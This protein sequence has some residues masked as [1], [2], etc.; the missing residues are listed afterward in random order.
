MLKKKNFNKNGK[1]AG[2]F[3]YSFIYFILF[4]WQSIDRCLC[5]PLPD[6]YWGLKLQKETSLET[7]Y[8]KRIT[9]FWSL[10]MFETVFPPVESLNGNN[11]KIDDN[12]QEQCTCLKWKE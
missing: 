8:A 2:D 3:F 5:L 6:W 12:Y 4:H 11:M 9:F 1:I 7:N 10:L